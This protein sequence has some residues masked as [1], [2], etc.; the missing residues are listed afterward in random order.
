MSFELYMD[1]LFVW[2]GYGLAKQKIIKKK[3]DI[4]MVEDK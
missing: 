3:I 4:K 1:M 2:P